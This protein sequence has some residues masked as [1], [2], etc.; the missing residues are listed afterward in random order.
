[1][2]TCS[3]C[4]SMDS[5]LGAPQILA[6]AGRPGTGKTFQLSTSLNL[7]GVTSVYF[8]AED[9]ESPNANTPVLRLRERLA[10]VTDLLRR[11]EPAALV[12][13]DADLLLGRF[14]STQKTH[15]LQRL[16]AELMR[17]AN[18][19]WAGSVSSTPLPIFMIGNDL[20]SLHQP[21]LRAGRA[22]VLQWDPRS[23]ELEEMV[24]SLFREISHAD[25]ESLVTAFPAQ[26]IAF[27]AALRASVTD[28]YWSA[29]LAGLEPAVLLRQVL[30]T[31]GTGPQPTFKLADL[32]RIGNALLHDHS[33]VSD[34]Q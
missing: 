13:D 9:V 33:G 5:M 25:V 7:A 8:A 15:N 28:A 14:A 17:V 27:F 19:R 22:R 18:A 20:A 1:M 21:L 31:R 30:S 16:I 23:A 26:P 11:G 34:A 12:L 29:Q 3:R 6:I 4:L 2:V 32:I 10:E 24:A